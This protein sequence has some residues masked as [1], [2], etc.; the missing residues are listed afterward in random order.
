MVEVFVG[1]LPD[2]VRNIEEQ[3]TTGSHV[4]I[5]SYAGIYLLSAFYP[6][7]RVQKTLR[8]AP[9]PCPERREIP[10]TNACHQPK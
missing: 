9:K 10:V 2:C 5:Y 8:A 1:D 6:Q 4:S 7:D 3:C